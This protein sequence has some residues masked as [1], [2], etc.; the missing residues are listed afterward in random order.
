[1]YGTQD[2]VSGCMVIVLLQPDSWA[3]V[4]Q[5]VFEFSFFCS[6]FIDFPP[7]FC[8]RDDVSSVGLLLYTSGRCGE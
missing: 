1:M 4:L 5:E 2:H 8:G 3:L 7:S 6:F